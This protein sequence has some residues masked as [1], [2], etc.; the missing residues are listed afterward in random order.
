MAKKKET[1]KAAPPV[2]KPEPV[3]EAKSESN[4][5]PAPAGRVILDAKALKGIARVANQNDGECR[6]PVLGPAWNALYQ[7]AARLAELLGD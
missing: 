7:A 4:H 2:T 6:D 1:E 5:V 3:P